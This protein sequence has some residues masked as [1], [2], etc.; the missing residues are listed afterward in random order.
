MKRMR[1][2]FLVVFFV[3]TIFFLADKAISII[4]TEKDKM[5]PEDILKKEE[6]ANAQ[7]IMTVFQVVPV[8]IKIEL[9]M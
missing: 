8:D 7:E 2:A 5:L 4:I 1:N 3:L 9:G 6:P